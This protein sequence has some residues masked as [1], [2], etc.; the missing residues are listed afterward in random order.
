MAATKNNRITNANVY[1]DGQNFLGMVEEINM[2]EV[3]FKGSDYKALGLFGTAEFTAGIEKIEF[4]LKSNSIYDKIL[5]KCN[6]FGTVALQIR[7]NLENWE[8]SNLSGNQ[9][10][11]CYMRASPA[12]IP[13]FS[14]KPQDN[15]ESESMFRV[16]Y[17]KLEIAGRVLVEID[18]NSNIFILNGKDLLA[19]YRA[20]LG[21]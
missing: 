13:G 16:Y 21:A 15:V 20:N 4:K 6:P 7:G 19:T 12:N 1:L 8:G 2:P 18:V 14:F 10:V 5:E 17:Y 3:K 9:S 11:V